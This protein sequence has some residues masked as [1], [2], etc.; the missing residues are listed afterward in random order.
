MNVIYGELFNYVGYLNCDSF[1]KFK[2]RI[3]FDYESKL[4][5]IF[6]KKTGCFF[7]CFRAYKS[8]KKL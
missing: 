7:D 2:L 1:R 8:K 5:F 4:I 3:T 6:K